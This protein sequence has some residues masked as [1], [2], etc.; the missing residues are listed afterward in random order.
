MEELRIAEAEFRSELPDDCHWET[1]W[2]ETSD[3]ECQIVIAVHDAHQ[4]E[5][6]LSLE[7]EDTIKQEA[8]STLDEKERGLAKVKVHFDD[9][10]AKKQALLDD[11]ETCRRDTTAAAELIEGL[12]GEKDT[13]KSRVQVAD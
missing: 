6:K 11:A 9:A 2:M 3:F 7:L 5:L 8:R 4:K 12:A 1:V 13:E 10:M